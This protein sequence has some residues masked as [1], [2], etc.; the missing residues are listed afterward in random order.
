MAKKRLFKL[1]IRLYTFFA[2]TNEVREWKIQKLERC[3]K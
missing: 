2:D 1:F 3:Y